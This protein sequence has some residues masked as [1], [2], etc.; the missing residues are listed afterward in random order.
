[1]KTI[2]KCDYY[3]DMLYHVP[4]STF[5]NAKHGNNPFLI[6]TALKHASYV[7]FYGIC[8]TPVLCFIDDTKD[9]NDSASAISS[10]NDA[11]QDEGN[12]NQKE[13]N[14]LDL[15]SGCGAMSTGLCLGA[16]LSGVK[17]VTVSHK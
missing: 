10:E 13:M 6:S 1:M 8:L 14:L 17:L 3:Y 2:A 4:F 11:N 12:K 5:L 15:F 7:V 9:E 16:N